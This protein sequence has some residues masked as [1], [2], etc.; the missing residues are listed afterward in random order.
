MK[1][2][3]ERLAEMKNASLPPLDWRKILKITGDLLPEDEIA[4]T[5]YFKQFLEP[6]GKCP[7][8][9]SVFGKSGIESFLLAG[10]PNR[11]TLNWGIANGEANCSK[12]GYLFRVYHRNV[13]PFEFL[14]LGLPYHPD[15]LKIS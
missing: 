10:A 2:F 8:C 15:T 5:E 7:C 9:D 6:T 14:N 11:A 13:G 12:C 4:L 1:N 3:A